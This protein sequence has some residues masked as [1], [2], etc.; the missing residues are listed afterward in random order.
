MWPCQATGGG[1]STITT[2]HGPD[3]GGLA[4]RRVRRRL[5]TG[6]RPRHPDRAQRLPGS[7]LVHD[8]GRGLSP[9]PVRR[10]E[11]APEVM[12]KGTSPAR[13]L[14]RLLIGRAEGVDRFNAD[15]ETVLAEARRRSNSDQICVPLSGVDF[16]GR[17]RRPVD[18]NG[19]RRRTAQPSIVR[20]G[21]TAPSCSAPPTMPH[22]RR[23]R[24]TSFAALDPDRACCV[25]SPTAALRYSEKSSA[26]AR[27]PY[28][29]PLA[30]RVTS[31]SPQIVRNTSA[32]HHGPPTVPNGVYA[33]QSLVPTSLND[34]QPCGA[35]ARCTSI[36]DSHRRASP[37]SVR[38]QPVC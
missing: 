24:R 5:G 9:V 12:L 31:S 11:L 20:S 2:H 35:S 36:S 16:Q 1:S 22:S 13:S 23:R 25:S 21:R 34:V 10:L 7:L 6:V 28:P 8:R 37:D 33:G 19:G 4:G 32:H 14:D 17:H 27:R 18:A 30:D 3:R 38:P 29:L 15:V 26:S